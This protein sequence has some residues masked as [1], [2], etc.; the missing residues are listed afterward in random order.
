[1]FGSFEISVYHIFEFISSWTEKKLRSILNYSKS[2]NIDILLCDSILEVD[3]DNIWVIFCVTPNEEYF[4]YILDEDS[5][6]NNRVRVTV[7]N[8]WCLTPLSTI[9]QLY[10]VGQFYWWRKS[11][12]PVKT[13]DLLYVTV[14]LYHIMLYQVLLI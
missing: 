6:T 13:T 3:Y 2:G 8:L 9:F 4:C 12:S 11:K 1:M 7:I 5:F 14:K 10:C